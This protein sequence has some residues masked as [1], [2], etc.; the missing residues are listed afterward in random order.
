MILCIDIDR[1]TKENIDHLV[2]Q[3]KYA[4]A[5]EVVAS[6]I[7]TLRT[8]QEQI[9]R[10]GQLVFVTPSRDG[11]K[12][13]FDR[14]PQGSREALFTIPTLFAAP[15]TINAVA[16]AE[17]SF[18][19][20]EE[21]PAGVEGWLFGQYNKLLP[22]K[23]SVRAV[24]SLQI[25]NDGEPI[26]LN[27]ASSRIAT[28]AVKLNEVLT[29]LDREHPSAKGEALRTAFPIN[30]PKSR[31]RF[32]NQ[33]V[34]AITRNGRLTGF[35]GDLLFAAT[36]QRDAQRK[37]VFALTPA[38]RE[39][40]ALPN[41][42]LDGSSPRIAARLSEEEKKF[43]IEHVR[44][45]VPAERGAFTAILSA[46]SNGAVTP[47]AIDESLRATHAS[48][49]VTPAFL[50][51]QRAGAISRMTDLD[52]VGRERSGLFVTYYIR[53]AGREWVDQVHA[54]AR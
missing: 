51:T 28:E 50:A 47:E 5:S 39:F 17:S 25:E 6:A 30:D 45:S 23:A 29:R 21:V 43:L 15:R 40:A 4:S 9:D 41:P 13:Q 3:G 7:E 36:V 19:T 20:T 38:G 14:H 2:E 44:R 46:L 24:A 48:A 37:Q 26:E 32:A 34:G 12:E 16:T 49:T 42:V 35:P 1:K 27:A 52:L 31:L 22:L 8:L 54:D 11:R 18:S 10:T 33:F 53:E